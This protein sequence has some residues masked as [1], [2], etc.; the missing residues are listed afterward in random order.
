MA[1]EWWQV[2]LFTKWRLLPCEI[3]AQIQFFGW[4]LQESKIFK[5]PLMEAIWK[6]MASIKYLTA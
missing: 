3:L 6:E 2:I 5:K 4:G 1:F